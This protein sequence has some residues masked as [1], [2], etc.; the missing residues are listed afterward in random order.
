MGIDEY[1]I[2]KKKQ[3]K[4][5]FAATALLISIAIALLVMVG[6]VL[7]LGKVNDK[8]RIAPRGNNGSSK[9]ISVNNNYGSCKGLNK[10]MVFNDNIKNI[11]DAA[12]SYFTNA[13]L[14]KELNESKKITLREMKEKKLVL[15][16]RDASAN[17]CDGNKS[18]V[19]VTKGVNEYIMKILLSCSDI[20]DHIIVHLGCYDYCDKDVCEKEVE[21]EKVYEYEYKKTTSC[22][23]SDWSSWGA[24][25]TIRE[26]T[27]NLKKEDTKVET[28]NKDT[29]YKYDAVASKTT[30]NCNK[31]SGYTLSGTK[32]VKTETINST[33]EKDTY[34]CDKYGSGYSL[35]GTKCIKN[36]TKR[37]YETATKNEPTYSCPSGYTKTT[38]TYTVKSGDTISSVASANN[39]SVSAL[40]L[41]NNLS[42]NTITVGQKLTIPAQYQT[43]C[44]K[45]VTRTDNQPAE[46]KTITTYVK[47]TCYEN[48]CST[49]F[50]PSC[51]NGICK[52][53]EIRTCDKVARTCQKPTQSTTYSCDKYNVDGKVYTKTSD[54]R[55]IYN[56]TA[57]EYT[58]ATKNTDTYN[59]S[60][61]SG[62]TLSG[63]QCYK[64]VPAVVDEKAA[65]V[66][67]GKYVCTS[68][69]SLTKDNKCSK[70]ITKDADKNPTTYSCMSDYTLT[71]DNKCTKTVSTGTKVTYYRYATRT[72]N[73][74]KTYTKWSL[75]KNDTSLLNDGY[76]LTGTKRI[77]KG[78]IEK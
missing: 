75:D 25:K 29:V 41:A 52:M 8:D 43:R 57:R 28:I 40:K 39:I 63:T 5:A 71:K 27:S 1:S 51:V 73:G 20:E 66:V 24:W 78:I 76:K 59:C 15:N 53:E 37:V 9:K 30:Y 14:P 48:I 6:A 23:M 47:G 55:C 10:E 62:Y 35:S 17:T 26:K 69:Y 58:N 77:Y 38:I 32:C 64:D 70:T 50:I 56:Y 49:D 46:G 67:T 7:I 34:N 42:S 68:G 54:N 18:Y 45:D 72:C 4:N 19:E 21:P 11:K 65:T 13:R 61:Y 22:T 33:K 44:Y 2:L 31:Y 16:V 74:G 3:K 60:K 36:G 12:I